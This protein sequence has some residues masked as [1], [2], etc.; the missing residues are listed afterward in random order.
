M[1]SADD[2]Y[3]DADTRAATRVAGALRRAR[4]ARDA[5]RLVS[6]EVAYEEALKAAEAA[7]TTDTERAAIAGELGLCELALQR[8]REAAG[9]LA[10]SLE[11]PGAL[12][13]WIHRRVQEGLQSAGKRVATFYVT[14]NPPGA[15]VFLDGEALGHIEPVHEVFLDPGD[16]TA[17]ARLEGHADAVR[18]FSAEAGQSHALVLKLRRAPEPVAKAPEAAPPPA[19]P[20]APAPPA[21]SPLPLAELRL[22][23]VALTTAT[24]AAGVVLLLRAAVLRDDLAERDVALRRQGWD[25]SVCQGANGS[26]TCAELRGLREERNRLGALGAAALVTSGVFATATVAWFLTDPSPAGGEPVRQGVR[27]VPVM[28]G[29]QAALSVQGTF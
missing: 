7:W 10:Q 22:G 14:T 15:E 19:R 16:H 6:A 28:T 9:H 4:Q 3:A 12:S 1:A 8:H 18:S 27:V 5:G 24:A 23:G 25:S 29:N 13:P 26:P 2:P 20:A 17:R 21:P 11:H